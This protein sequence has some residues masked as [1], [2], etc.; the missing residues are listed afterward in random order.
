V[1]TSSALFEA[2]KAFG[3]GHPLFGREQLVTAIADG[4]AFGFSV[5]TC[6]VP[7]HAAARGRTPP[8]GVIYRCRVC[9]LE[10]AGDPGTGDLTVT[11]FVPAVEQPADHR[12]PRRR[13]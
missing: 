13:P 9:R 2:M 12:C 10:F 3:G 6:R 5:K 4:L 8:N 1:Q 11:P 7:Y